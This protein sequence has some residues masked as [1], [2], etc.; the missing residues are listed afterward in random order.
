MSDWSSG[1]VTSV[2]YVTACY[3]DQAPIHLK[4][5]ALLQGVEPPMPRGRPAYCE[6]GCGQG[7]TAILIALTN[8]DTDVHAIDFMPAQI[9]RAKAMAADFGLDN[10]HF[11]EASFADLAEGKGPALPGFDYVT[12]HGVYSWISRDNQKAIVKFLAEKLNPG[13]LTYTSYNALPGWSHGIP[14]QRLLLEYA[15]LARGPAEARVTEGFEFMRQLFEAKA[16]HLV[17]NDLAQEQLAK[18][19]RNAAYLAHEYLN[20]YWRPLFFADVARDFA[21]A[22]LEYAGTARPIDV[23]DQLS[24]S[25]E[26]RALIDRIPDPI[27]AE[28]F[29]DYCR[30]RT[31]RADIHVKGARRLT[32]AQRETR[33]AAVPLALTVG[34]AD[35]RYDI[36]L[37][38]KNVH[39]PDETFRPLV[40]ALAEQGPTPLGALMRQP[41]Y[42]GQPIQSMTG[43]IA[44]LLMSRQVAAALPF[45][46]AAALARCRRANRYFAER[47]MELETR[48]GVPVATPVL[49]NAHHLDSVDVIAVH[50]INNLA[51]TDDI[52]IARRLIE[53]ARAGGD[54]GPDDS[55]AERRLATMI[56]DRR[57]IWR[58]MGLMD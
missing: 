11:Y 58:H 5:M 38:H 36:D 13:G 50:L 40:E 53:F 26:Q 29:R 30:M 10:V 18:P 21:E 54:Q 7:L 46:D 43:T 56:A 37:P 35:F 28:T 24:L 41:G 2:E 55:E 4:L 39:L 51:D 16:T 1:Y 47:S 15:G 19:P 12:M 33:L 6:L 8:P 20:E 22:K 52:S 49:R 14:V 3:P 34:A 25:D 17:D 45:D 48:Q 9:A 32:P 44:T 31:F 42:A 23:L 57:R 27:V